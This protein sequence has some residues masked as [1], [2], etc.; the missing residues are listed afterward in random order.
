MQQIYENAFITNTKPC[1][2]YNLF[3]DPLACSIFVLYFMVIHY[4]PPESAPLTCAYSTR[5]RH[6]KRTPISLSY[7]FT[8][9]HSKG[10]TT[11]FCMAKAALPCAFYHTHGETICHKQEPKKTLS[12]VFISAHDKKQNKKIEMQRPPHGTTTMSSAA[13]ITNTSTTTTQALPPP[14]PPPPPRRRRHH[15]QP[16]HHHHLWREII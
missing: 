16:A 12:W 15:H 7:F 3:M 13:T 11:V 14:P 8:S 9:V 5:Q 6:E 10:R 4:G 2:E 1:L